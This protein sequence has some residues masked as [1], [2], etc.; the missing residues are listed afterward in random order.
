VL[1]V[2]VCVSKM[3]YC[4]IAS[5]C[6]QKNKNMFSVMIFILRMILYVSNYHVYAHL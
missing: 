2:Y 6:N 3:D 4:S 1:Q 5:D